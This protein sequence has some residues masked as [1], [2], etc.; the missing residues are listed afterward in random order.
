MWHDVGSAIAEAKLYRAGFVAG[1]QWADAL[2]SRSNSLADARLEALSQDLAKA[3]RLAESEAVARLEAE[4]RAERLKQD[5]V[6]IVELAQAR[7]SGLRSGIGEEQRRAVKSALEKERAA[8]GLAKGKLAAEIH[9]LIQSAHAVQGTAIPASELSR[10][11]QVTADIID[12]ATIHISLDGHSFIGEPLETAH[13]VI[14]ALLGSGVIGDRDALGETRV[15]P[16]DGGEEVTV[17]DE[18]LHPEQ[19]MLTRSNNWAL[20]KADLV[21]NRNRWIL[22]A[23]NVPS[24]TSSQLRSGK[25]RHFR[26]EE[27][28]HFEFVT[29]KPRNPDSPYLPRRT[30]LWGRFGA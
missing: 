24:S 27:L 17:I 29:R 20:I 7:E 13:E 30:D 18:D 6:R 26:G 8:N 1:A 23:E 14:S 16:K 21:A 19:T 5:L 9:S 28:N 4:A 11:I 3:L 10:M 12:Q 15:R 2:L 22:I 25:N